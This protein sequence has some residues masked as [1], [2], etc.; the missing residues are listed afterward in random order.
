MELREYCRQLEVRLKYSEFEKM[1]MAKE[2]SYIG[3]R[4]PTPPIFL[5]TLQQFPTV[6]L[7]TKAVLRTS[8]TTV[9]ERSKSPFDIPN[10]RQKLVP[11]P[12]HSSV[13]RLPSL[14]TTTD[15]PPRP[16]LAKL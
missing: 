11:L 7:T 5:E 12:Q 9:K 15:L 8:R 4:E 3:N 10:T 16:P 2:L 6:K 14:G 13:A 1:K